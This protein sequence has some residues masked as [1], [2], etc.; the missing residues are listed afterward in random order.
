MVR[1][2]E[3]VCGTWMSVDSGLAYVE[4]YSGRVF[5]HANRKVLVLHRDWNDCMDSVAGGRRLMA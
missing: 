1:A 4:Q 3:A 5:G 2:L